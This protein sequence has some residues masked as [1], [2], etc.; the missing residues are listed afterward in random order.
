MMPQSPNFSP[1]HALINLLVRVVIIV[2]TR[3]PCSAKTRTSFCTSLFLALGIPHPIGCTP[4]SPRN[5]SPLIC[6][7]ICVPLTEGAVILDGTALNGLVVFGG[8]RVVN[9]A[10]HLLYLLRCH[11]A[12][13]AE[14][15]RKGNVSALIER[16]NENGPLLQEVLVLQDRSS[17]VVNVRLRPGTGIT[18]KPVQLALVKQYLPDRENSAFFLHCDMVLR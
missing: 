11:G 2:M 8:L 14:V 15:P 18:R 10:R 1:F 5:I 13:V 12:L 4:S 7:N 9:Y 16:N 17:G 3:N 6:R